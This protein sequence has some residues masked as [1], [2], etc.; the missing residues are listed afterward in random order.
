MPTS[1]QEFFTAKG[2]EFLKQ[3]I[4]L[5]LTE[6]GADLTAAAIFTDK[7]ELEAI[8]VAKEETLVVGT[9]IIDLVFERLNAP[10][11][12]TLLVEEGA[13]V[14]KDTVIAKIKARACDLLKAER[15]I[16]N[17]VSHLSGI[18]NLTKKY[19]QALDG[20]KVKLLDTRKTTPGLRWVEKY[21]VQMAG[22]HN[23]RLDL[24]SMLMLK[25]NHIDAKGSIGQAVFELRKTYSPCPAIEVECRTLEDVQA[26]VASKCERI[27][28]D[29]MTPELIAKALPLIPSEI[30]CEI[31]GG[32]T[33]DN[34]ADLAK[35]GERQADFISV[36][37]LTHSAKAADFSLRIESVTE[38]IKRLKKELGDKLCIMGHHYQTDA[39][40][41]HCD[42]VGDSLELSRKV[43]GISAD[44]IVFCGVYFMAESA[45]L[46]T[47]ENQQVFL[48]EP[49]SDC[50]MARMATGPQAEKVILQ[51][52]EAG[53]DIVP[54]AY[55]NTSL[56]LKAVVGKYGG[57]VCTSANAAIML[58][59][60]LSKASQVLFLPD[61]HL[62]RNTAKKI[63]LSEDDYVQL[64]ISGNGI[65]DLADPN[66]QKKILLWPGCCP[67]HG[68]RTCQEVAEARKLAP[69][70]P[71]YVHPECPKE[72]VDAVDG[73]G[74]TS[75]LIKKVG[76]LAKQA[77]QGGEIKGAFIGTESNLVLRLAKRYADQFSV[78][79]LFMAYC[80]DMNAI[81][82][83]KLLHVLQ[84]IANGTASEV[85]IVAAEKDPAKQALQ[86]ML[87]VC[88][89]QGL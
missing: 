33:L 60:A 18:A 16:L 64:N 51:L 53:H 9:P 12:T 40:I 82:E 89:A 32:V 67:I 58:Q 8:I 29:N 47:R 65:R 7:D 79:P 19:V 80:P 22:G 24:E 75:F 44:Y 4:D 68:Q 72:V 36:G 38:G 17:Y 6:D 71:I 76:E 83:Q 84:N 23:H 25:D 50:M 5:A 37:R 21:A 73:A 26:A 35:I 20:T 85:Q 59:W 1:W 61:K 27:M 66:L 86:T 43:P 45:A 56:D 3:N 11:K 70:Y 13:L 62:G 15:V 42:I 48:P 10:C 77:A 52:K 28:L 54:L 55:V 63:G 57:A 78:K 30:E 2:L 81:T 88:A 31:S 46:L 49:D 39:I 69:T 41:Q 74:S 34:I 87:D 14:S